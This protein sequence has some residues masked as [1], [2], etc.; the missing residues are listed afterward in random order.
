MRLGAVGDVLQAA[1]V[2]RLDLHV[3][4]GSALIIQRYLSCS[5]RLCVRRILQDVNLL[6]DGTTVLQVLIEAAV[7]AL[8]RF[9]AFL[10]VVSRLE[11]VVLVDETG[12][13]VDDLTTVARDWIA[14]PS[15]KVRE[16]VVLLPD[17]ALRAIDGHQQAIAS[18]LL[19]LHARCP[20]ILLRYC[21]VSVVM[22]RLN[23]VT[24]RS[25]RRWHHH[26][27]AQSRVRVRSTTI[28]IHI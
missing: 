22:I 14:V 4:A 9:R 21:C 26:R 20:L 28:A 1:L 12:A 19:V 15:R 3:V 10:R 17:H 2:T 13:V 25:L 27:L 8:A 16:L 5:G 6:I 7:P 24:L 11:H 23:E 18:W